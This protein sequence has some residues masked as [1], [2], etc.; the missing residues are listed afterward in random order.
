MITILDLSF[1]A[2]ER[3][4]HHHSLSQS[5]ALLSSSMSGVYSSPLLSSE[6]LSMTNKEGKKSRTGDLLPW[7]IKAEG[8]E[9]VKQWVGG[10][11]SYHM[12]GIELFIISWLV[13]SGGGWSC[14]PK[15]KACERQT[16]SLE[17][18]ARQI[19]HRK[20]YMRV[21]REVRHRMTVQASHDARDASL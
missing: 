4:V 15:C 1:L 13:E 10:K 17:H 11:G 12:G 14:R 19:H 2:Q 5:S 6:R 21:T 8:G 16:L 18:Q 7:I 20:R 3:Q 9:G